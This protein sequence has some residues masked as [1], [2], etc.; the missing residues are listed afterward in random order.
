MQFGQL[1]RRE[2][3]TLLGG[4]AAAWPTFGLAQI[5]T[6]RPLIAVLVSGT[7]AGW[8][9]NVI[10]F[11]QRLQ[12]LGYVEGRDLD[13]VDRYGEGDVARMPALAEELVRSSPIS[14]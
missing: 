7:A 9:P 13:I 1:K 11:Q 10:A 6:K 3:I 8:S 14:S 5:S 4:A 2:V 12:Q